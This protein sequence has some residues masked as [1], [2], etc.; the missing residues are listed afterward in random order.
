VPDVEPPG[1]GIRDELVGNDD[2]LPAPSNVAGAFA[3][4]LDV[5]PATCGDGEFRP[6]ICTV[7][8]LVKAWASA[9]GDSGFCH[10][11]IYIQYPAAASRHMTTRVFI[12]FMSVLL[13]EPFYKSV[14]I[15]GPIIRNPAN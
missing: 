13:D 15:S 9:G 3:G 12:E 5:P 4:P 10:M 14:Q 8:G 6:G 2:V 7:G 11:Y 1:P